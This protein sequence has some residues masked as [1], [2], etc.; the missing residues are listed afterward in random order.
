MTFCRKTLVPDISST[1]EDQKT[2]RSEVR[3]TVTKVDVKPVL[4]D[5]KPVYRASNTMSDASLDKNAADS[6]YSDLLLIRYIVQ[7][8]E[9]EFENYVNGSVE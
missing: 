8:V 3:A 9:S 5:V 4:R 2:T 1:N 7:I 6:A